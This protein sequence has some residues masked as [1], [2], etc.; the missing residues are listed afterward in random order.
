MT[1][2]VHGWWMDAAIDH[3]RYN[4]SMGPYKFVPTETLD[5][6]T[7]QLF[8]T[9]DED[10]RMELSIGLQKEYYDQAG[11]N[12][13]LWVPS[14]HAWRNTLHNAMDIYWPSTFFD[15]SRMWTESK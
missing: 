7:T 1:I 3:N 5:N 2:M 8:E 11:M 10:K 13:L 4:A 6:L 9:F 14:P 12:I 15:L